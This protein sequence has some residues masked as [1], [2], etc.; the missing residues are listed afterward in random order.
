MWEKAEGTLLPTQLSEGWPE[1]GDGAPTWVPGPACFPSGQPVALH[2]GA[3][4][5]SA[6][7]FVKGHPSREFKSL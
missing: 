5:G 6:A 4:T 7:C 3:V 1:P 2:K